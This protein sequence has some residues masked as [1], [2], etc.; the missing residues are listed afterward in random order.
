[1]EGGGRCGLKKKKNCVVSEDRAADSTICE[2]CRNKSRRLTQKK[3]TQSAIKLAKEEIDETFCYL[4]EKFEK[5]L[6][7]FDIQINHLDLVRC[8]FI[9]KTTSGED[10]ATKKQSTIKEDKATNKQIEEIS[11]A[12]TNVSHLRYRLAELKKRFEESPLTVQFI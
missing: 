8:E 2:I 12:K 1:M 7:D 9:F 4:N 6:L 11:R 5:F 10:K 3:L